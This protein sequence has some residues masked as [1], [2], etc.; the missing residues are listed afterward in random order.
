MNLKCET[1]TAGNVEDLGKVIEL[2]SQSM[3][4]TTKLNQINMVFNPN[5]GEFNALV[6]YF[7]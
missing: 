5:T 7:T 4:I 1:L 6:T 2:W 3:P